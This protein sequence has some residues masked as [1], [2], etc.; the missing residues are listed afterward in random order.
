MQRDLM[1]P[2]ECAPEDSRNLIVISAAF[3]LNAKNTLSLLTL[4]KVK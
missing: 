2:I 4:L 3:L 1:Y